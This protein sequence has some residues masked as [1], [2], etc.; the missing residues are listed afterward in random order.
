MIPCYSEFRAYALVYIYIYIYIYTTFMYVCMYICI[1]FFLFGELL[2]TLS[3]EKYIIAKVP[4]R[5]SNTSVG[6]LHIF[7]L[8]LV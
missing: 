5:Q 2:S 3:G 1:F 4:L 7:I 6:H 8:R